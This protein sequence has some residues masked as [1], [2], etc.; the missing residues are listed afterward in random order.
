[1]RGRSE[2]VVCDRKSPD[3]Y[4]FKGAIKFIE[5]L[6]GVEVLTFADNVPGAR[7]GVLKK[8]NRTVALLPVERKAI[9]TEPRA[10]VRRATGAK[11]APTF[12]DTMDGPYLFAAALAR[13]T[14]PSPR[15]AV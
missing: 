1:M 15:H 6:R 13:C 12:S 5:Q 8:H 4:R 7:G 3:T 11:E 14:A 2:G 9:E 10:T